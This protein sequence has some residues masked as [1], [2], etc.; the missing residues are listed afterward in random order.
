MIA[1]KKYQVKIKKIP[2]FLFKICI[3]LEKTQNNNKI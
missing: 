3:L 1:T 2:F